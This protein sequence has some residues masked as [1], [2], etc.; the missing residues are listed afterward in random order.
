[1]QNFLRILN[2]SLKEIYPESEIHVFGNLLLEKI[3]GLSR[4]Q[5]LLHNNLLLNDEQNNQAIQF[6]E[7][8]KKQEPIQYV[9]GETEFYGLKFKVN[10]SVLIPRPETEELVEW[11]ISDYSKQNGIMILDIGTGSGCIP[12]SLKA[13]LQKAKVYALDI[14]EDSLKIARE[15]AE[16]NHVEIEFFRND[17]LKPAN[18]DKQW[19]VI[20]SNPP[21]I[22][23]SEKNEIEKNVI[24]FEPHLALF[25][26]NKNPLLFYQKIAEFALIH[27]TSLGKLYFEIHKDYAPECRKLL[28]D[29][30]FRNVEIRK[31]I[32][33]NDRMI[34]ASRL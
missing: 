10:G 24:D 16:L 5:L 6:I 15:N 14:S 13:K 2:S 18:I 4:T 8:L 32:C 27:L 17:I 31:D 19:N 26:E 28:E 9:L 29:Y 1:M 30:G 23:V 25:V 11:I 33:G 22:P 7:R 12:I 34:K 20:V 21:Y 3:T